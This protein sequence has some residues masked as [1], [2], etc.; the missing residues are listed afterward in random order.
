MT[1][2]LIRIGTRASQLALWQANHVRERL[3]QEH[4]GLSI[5][6]VTITTEGDRIL[7]KPLRDLGG[8]ALF[9]K[10]IETALL[11]G[12]IDLAVHSL[13]DVPAELP[14]E[15]M[16]TA[17]LRR[18]NPCDAL[19][20]R[21]G[22]ELARE[23]VVATGSLRRRIQLS[24]WRPDLQFEDIRGNIDTRLNKLAA[25]QYDAL[26]LAAAGLERM[27]WEQR[28]SQILKPALIIPSAGQGAIS[29]E[30]RRDNVNVQNLI[31]PL[32]DYNSACCVMAERTFTRLVEGD[33]SMPVAAWA[34]LQQHKLYLSACIADINDGQILK[35]E[36]SGEMSQ[37]TAIGEAASAD[38]IKQG[39]AHIIARYRQAK[40]N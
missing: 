32:N 12:S 6:L 21:H 8:K 35:T 19:V 10:E 28:I 22:S 31:M 25:G 17:T 34:R 33:C 26:V 1:P 14:P 5:E 27:G 16:L 3:L 20:L 30:V 40:Q 2:D 13:K 37:F 11:A 38:I 29:I 36:V 4:A 7:D 18:A 23:S 39:G 24:N 9:L 15:L